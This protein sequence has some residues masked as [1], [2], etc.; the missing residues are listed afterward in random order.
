MRAQ[1]Q[2]ALVLHHRAYSET[3]L[4]LEVFTRDSGRIGLIAKGARRPKSKLRGVLKPFQPLLIGWSGRGELGVLTG[5]ETDGAE[6]Y[7]AGAATYCGFYMNELLVRLL[8]R[9]DPHEALFES[10][11]A[12]LGMLTAERSNETALRIFEKRLLKELGYGLVLDRDVA[13]N[14]PIVGEALYDFIFDRGP[15]RVARPDLH[16]RPLGFRL[17]GASLRALAEESLEDA[18]ALRE[19]KGLM[20]A[21][22]ERHLGDKPLHSRRLF[23]HPVRPPTGIV[24]DT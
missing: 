11:C 21:V 1:S 4:L 9:H 7:L 12:T 19:I 2:S 5:A 24:S 8:H 15:V 10:Y 17:R 23:A 3:S 6:R 16:T 14:S 20:R 18:I 13:D 22:L